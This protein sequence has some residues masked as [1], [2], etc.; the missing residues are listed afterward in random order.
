MV[1]ITNTG[2]APLKVLDSTLTGPFKLANPN[3]FDNLSLGAGQSVDVTVLFNRAAYIP[4]ANGVTGVFEGRLTLHTNEATNS[5]AKVNLSGF[6]QQR[7]EGGWEPNVNEVWKMFGFGNVI[8]GL[9][10]NAGGEFSTLS[11]HDVY[12]PADDTEVLSRYWRIAD[13]VTSAKVTQIAGFHKPA[14]A[15]FSIHAPGSKSAAV[16]ITY[17][18]PL[19]NQTVLPLRPNG[20]FATGTFT[21]TTVPDAWTGNDIFGFLVAGQSTNP[22][23]NP[24]GAGAPTQ[25][26]LDAR[27]PGYTVK[28]GNVFDPSGKAVPDGYT[29]RVFQ[30]FNSEGHIFKNTYLVIQDYTGIN[31]DYNDNIYVVQGIAP[32]FNGTASAT[33]STLGKLDEAGP[34]T[35]G[36]G[37]LDALA[38]DAA[39]NHLRGGGGDDALWG[40]GGDDVLRGGRGEDHLGGGTGDD[41]LVGGAGRD[42][43]RGGAGGDEFVFTAL[44]DS[45]PGRAARDV[46]ADFEPG[47]DR[48]VLRA[49]DAVADEPGHQGFTLDQD[50]SFS[51]GEIRLREV[52]AGLLVELNVDDDARPEMT[53]LV[54]GGGTLTVDD[55]VL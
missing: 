14:G 51:A 5:T 22:D 53:I 33:T 17:H 36:H 13:G 35:A 49:I 8:E 15:A 9:S 45:G 46:I 24:T 19:Q 30:A 29:V 20:A 37:L 26:Q 23:L 42:V 41:R 32:V 16:Q 10:L 21:K 3:V 47:Q 52:K 27:Y 11:F 1:Q 28:N 34:R 55:F 54:R 44:Q 38:G 6:W 4:K 43:L 18:D 31:Y 48:I 12:L 7:D 25:A 39:A 40:R 50:G 2:A